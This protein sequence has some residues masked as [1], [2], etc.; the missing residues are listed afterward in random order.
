MV[1]S[2]IPKDTIVSVIRDN[3]NKLQ[4]T[5]ISTPTNSPGT[6]T[7]NASLSL[8]MTQTMFYEWTNTPENHARISTDDESHLVV[9]TPTFNN[10]ESAA[11]MVFPSLMIT[12]TDIT[13]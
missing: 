13:Q 2:S 3:A 9:P 1:T 8:M 12:P 5:M 11:E 7:T 6:A 4:T 10:L